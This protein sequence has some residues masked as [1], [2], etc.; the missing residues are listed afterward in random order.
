MLVDVFGAALQVMASMFEVV[1][2]KKSREETVD[3]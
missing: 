1:V 2:F 3:R